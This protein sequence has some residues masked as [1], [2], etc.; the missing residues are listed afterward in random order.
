[1]LIIIISKSIPF[2]E[3]TFNK[4]FCRRS[5]VSNIDSLLLD[6]WHDFGLCFIIHDSFCTEQGLEII[7]WWEEFLEAF[8]LTDPWLWL[9]ISLHL[10]HFYQLEAIWQEL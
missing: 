9:R 3:L 6:G 2:L 8:E 5:I 4:F 7:K 1:M 10:Y